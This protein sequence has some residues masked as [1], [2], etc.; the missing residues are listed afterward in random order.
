[1]IT[2]S[3]T[4]ISHLPVLLTFY[5]NDIQMVRELI[6]VPLYLELSAL[7]SKDLKDPFHTLCA[8]LK[9]L[10]YSSNDGQ[11]ILK[12]GQS[13]G[14]FSREAHPL[15]KEAKSEMTKLI[16]DCCTAL[17]KEFINFTLEGEEGVLET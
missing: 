9:H 16:D 5:R 12:S 10:L 14:K 11:I 6:K 13:L 17:K 1:M 8:T 2:L 4:I 15:Q 7:A 3:T